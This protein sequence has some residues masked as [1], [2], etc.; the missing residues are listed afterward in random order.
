MF[1]DYYDW[2]PGQAVPPSELELPNYCPAPETVNFSTGRRAPL[3]DPS[4][5]DCHAS[6]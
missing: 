5:V 2:L 4:C 1:A 3:A 6:R